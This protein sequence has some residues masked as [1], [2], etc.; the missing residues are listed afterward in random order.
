MK[1]ASF[2]KI[3]V[4]IGL[5]LS[6]AF[7]GKKESPYYPGAYTQ[8]PSS[9]RYRSADVSRVCTAGVQHARERGDAN[10]RSRIRANVPLD[11]ILRLGMNN[12]QNILENECY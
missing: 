7:C 1:S 4:Y 6:L 8:Q 9:S 11:L 10:L 3:I 2:K 5:A 12:I